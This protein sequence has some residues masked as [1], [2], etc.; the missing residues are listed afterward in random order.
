[1][2]N[3]NLSSRCPNGSTYQIGAGA[4]EDDHGHGTNVAGI[5]TS[6]GTVAPKGVAPAAQI[7]AFKIIDTNNTFWFS[8]LN[9]ALDHILFSHSEVDLVNM[10][11]G[12]FTVFSPGSCESNAVVYNA[13]RS[14]GKV[15][16]VASMNNGT[17]NG[18]AFPACVASVI[19][20]GAV[21][22]ANVGVF[23]S[24][25]CS[26]ASTIAG[27]VA[28]WS[29]SDSSLDILAPGCGTHSTG[30]FNSSSAFCGT[31]QAT[32]HAAGVAALL[33]QATPSLTAA[34]IE[35]SLETRAV[36]VA[37]GGN[38][39]TKPRI[40][41]LM[42]FDFD[43]DGLLNPGDTDDDN[44]A[45]PDTVEITCGSDLLLAS[46]VPERIDTPADDDVDGQ[47]NEALPSGGVQQDC[48]GDGYT[49][50]AEFAITANDQDPCG[51][52]GWPS[53]L[54][55]GGAQPNTLNVQDLAS[56]LTPVRRFG[57]SP[58]HPAY[59]V[60]WDLVPGTAIGGAINVQDVAAPFTG[61]TG[62]PRMFG[63]ARAFGKACPWAP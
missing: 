60:R 3:P 17:K 20:V 18:M 30:R 15:P 38:G 22:D 47:T 21:Y 34:Q 13:L 55:A 7:A 39:L 6:N 51:N 56:F 41:A 10:S 9:A 8:D 44:D 36:G 27:K 33:L 23:G 54:V 29:N 5:I 61:A 24:A 1:M 50:A 57:T 43:G 42:A 35:R 59:S 19:S 63:G 16:F 58:G 14:S 28:C 53:D 2:A 37:D 45:V 52:S 46:S 12:S 4:A 40:D 62:Y 26:D 48:D 25:S 31:S 32:P 49:R 11:L